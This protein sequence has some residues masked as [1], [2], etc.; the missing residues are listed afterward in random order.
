M[1][2][3]HCIYCNEQ[4][5]EKNV[6][7][8]KCGKELDELDQYL[9]KLIKGDFTGLAK[10]KLI[11]LIEAFI[12]QHIYGIV[13]TMT[14]IISAAT[15]IIV[16]AENAPV[17]EEFTNPPVVINTSQK[18]KQDGIAAQLSEE[19]L[20]NYISI[21][22]QKDFNNYDRLSYDYTF[23][24]NYYDELVQEGNGLEDFIKKYGRKVLYFNVYDIYSYENYNSK[25][26][27][28]LKLVESTYLKPLT[29][30]NT[31]PTGEDIQ[32]DGLED[33]KGYNVQV[34][35]CEDRVCRK[36]YINTKIYQVIFIKVNGEWYYL[37]SS[38]DVARSPSEYIKQVLNKNDGYKVYE[39][40][41]RYRDGG[42]REDI[43]HYYENEYD[44]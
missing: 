1:E 37:Y 24:T 18:V 7:C 2:K 41:Y 16:R 33:V 38:I 21:L 44:Y 20:M 34:M 28:E 4:N 26:P 42:F 12:K 3:I 32:I 14:V 8:S 35:A 11:F 5:D 43:T 6:K 19:Q 31:L 29:D 27:E 30:S 9:L 23:G 10:D 40:L 25:Y 36:S 17:V 15:N 22:D 13:L 39:T